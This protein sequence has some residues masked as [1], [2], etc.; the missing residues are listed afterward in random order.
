MEFLLL[1]IGIVV[2]VIGIILI[3]HHKIKIVSIV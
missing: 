2:F 3:N 1:D